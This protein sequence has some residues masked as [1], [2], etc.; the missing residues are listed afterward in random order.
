MHSVLRVHPETGVNEFM[1]ERAHREA[2][3]GGV[4]M[5]TK[6]I[7]Y[8]VPTPQAV[9]A[10]VA[11]QNGDECL[12]ENES[13]VDSEWKPSKTVVVAMQR[14]CDETRSGWS[15]SEVVEGL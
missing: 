7:V 9:G 4:R 10:E 6:N 3:E 1:D 5:S 8:L 11:S 15:Q 14:K 12:H 2:L 13:R